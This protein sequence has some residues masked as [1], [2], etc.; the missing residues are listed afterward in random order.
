MSKHP[1]T[2]P[3][4]PASFIRAD[5]TRRHEKE[6]HLTCTCGRNFTTRGIIAHRNSVRHHGIEHPPFPAMPI[7]EVA[8]MKRA[9]KEE[10]ARRLRREMRLA[11][12]GATA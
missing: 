10:Q 7:G 9:R 6:L 8:A 12:D 5:I 2:W 4:C 1:C 11:L 3:G